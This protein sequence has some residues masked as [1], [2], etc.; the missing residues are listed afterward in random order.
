MRAAGSYD[1]VVKGDPRTYADLAKPAGLAQ[2]AAYDQASAQTRPRSSKRR[3]GKLLA[4]S[5]LIGDA[6]KAGLIMHGSTFRAENQF[7]SL[8]FRIGNPVDPN[9]RGDFQAELELFLKLG[10]DWCPFG[11][12][13]CGGEGAQSALPTQ[14]LTG[15]PAYILPAPARR[16]LPSRDGWAVVAIGATNPI[17]KCGIHA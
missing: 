8:D 5:S 4:P 1:F 17:G 6:H 16:S 2:I 11:S 10:I 13:R 14:R 12:F 7:L 3:A 15:K 9:Q